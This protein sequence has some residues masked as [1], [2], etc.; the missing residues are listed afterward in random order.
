VDNR[1]CKSCKVIKSR[2]PDGVFANG[3]NKR[4][5]DD[6]NLL[7]SGSTCGICNQVRLKEH[8]KSKRSSKNG[9]QI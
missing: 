7:W 9:E 4:F 6:D 3:K 2:I 8:M 1:I 5:R